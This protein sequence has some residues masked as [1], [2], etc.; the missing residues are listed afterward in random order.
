M[1]GFAGMTR[2]SMRSRER[3]EVFGE[4]ARCIPREVREKYAVLSLDRDGR[5][6]RQI[7]PCLFRN[8]Q[9]DHLDDDP[10]RYSPAQVCGLEPPRPP[11][12]RESEG[13]VFV[14]VPRSPIG[15]SSSSTRRP[16]SSSSERLLKTKKIPFGILSTERFEVIT[17]PVSN[18]KD[19][20]ES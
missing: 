11:D 16:T 13:C 10:D 5:Y 18:R 7:D 4:A 2:L 14:R 9:G 20:R 17:A 15:T 19:Y 1:S 6:A 3:L 8:Q 12:G